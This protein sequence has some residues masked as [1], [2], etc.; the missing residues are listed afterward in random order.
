MSGLS[1]DIRYAFRMFRR[2]YVFS[3]VSIVALA[4]GIAAN[5]AIFSLVNAVLLRQLPFKDPGRLVWI[6]ASLTDREK[7]FFSIPDFIDTREQTTTLQALA[8]FT[9]WGANL[10][11]KGE[12]ER[13]QGVRV[14]SNAFSVLGVD[15]ARGRTIQ[16]YDDQPGAER[17]VVISYGLWKR[18]FGADPGLVGTTLTLNGDAYTIVGVL[19]P[20]FIFPGQLDAE[21]AIPLLLDSDPR[22]SLRDIN[23]IRAFGRMGEHE[24]L[25]QVRSDLASVTNNLREQY[26][27]TNAKKTAPKVSGLL[28]ELVG[29]YRTALFMLLG[30]V[31]L[32]LLIACSNLA[33]LLLARASSR[34]REFALR[35]ALGATGKRLTRQLLTESILL[36]L[37]GGAVGLVLAW[38]SIKFIV[39]LSPAALPRSGEVGIDWTVL[40]FTMIMSALAGI[41]FGLAPAI[42][43]SKVDVND[44]IKGGGRGFMDSGQ[45]K[46]T[47]SLLVVSEV[48]LSLV[49]LIGAGLLLK[50]FEKLQTVSTGLSTRNLLLAQISFQ[51]SKYSTSDEVKTF[52]EKMSAELGHLPGVKSVAAS[53][54]VPLSAM[55]S[56]SEFTIVGHPPAS[57]TD[58]PGAQSRWISPGY[59]AT[60]EIPLLRGREFEEEDSSASRAVVVIDTALADRFFPGMDPLGMHVKL[61]DGSSAMKDMEIIGIVGNVKHFSLEEDPMPT[62]YT[63]FYQIPKSAIPLN[64]ANR[65]TLVLRSSYDPL[66]LANTVRTSVRGVDSDIPATSIKTMDQLL[67]FSVGPRRF[68]MILLG[69]FALAALAL[70]IT[71]VYAVISYSVNQSVGEIGI[72]MSLGALPNDVLK[73]VVGKGFMPVAVGLVIGLAGALILTRVTSSLLYGISAIDPFI[74]AATPLLLLGISSLA[75]YIPARRATQVD[76]AIALRRA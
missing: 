11:D 70:A 23:F 20:D 44:E 25:Q 28:D 9:P 31:A 36:A 27:L 14:T 7:A 29:E 12:P 39:S 54:I 22:R 68:N 53:S 2:N 15:A 26:P 66:L 4:I 21:V 5:T 59:F 55:N 62:V 76:P 52:Y 58:V 18:R 57:P 61:E 8:G 24:T 6:W 16:S 46:R 42:Q 40:G 35:V 45:L 3:I 74:F 41:L 30:A 33:N 48:A 34:K 63:P 47:R 73:L 43:A 50:S 10:T 64:L 65:M 49:L 71:G 13:F 17:V 19:Q 60:M 1:Q 67:A 38:R 72:R 37:I 32:V 75:I 69:F 51:P 56:R